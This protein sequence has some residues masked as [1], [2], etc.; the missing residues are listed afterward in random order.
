MDVVRN[1]MSQLVTS[2]LPHRASFLMALTPLPSAEAAR[3]IKDNVKAAL[4][5]SP[6]IA[7]MEQ[8]ADPEREGIEICAELL[9]EF[10]DH[11]RRFGG[12]PVATR[13]TRRDTRRNRSLRGARITQRHVA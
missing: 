2:K 6:V 1:Y 3:W 9:A 7:R 13:P 8:A 4:V 11:T 10:G 5:P 12:K